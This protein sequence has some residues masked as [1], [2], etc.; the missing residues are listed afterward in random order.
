MARRGHTE[1]MGV[2]I[3]GMHERITQLGGRFEIRSGRRE[4]RWSR[5]YRCRVFPFRL[6]RS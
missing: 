1:K 2:G 3:Q 5:L 6:P 4:P